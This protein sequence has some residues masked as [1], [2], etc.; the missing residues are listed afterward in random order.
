MLDLSE[1]VGVLLVAVLHFI[2]DA[3]DPAGILQQFAAATAPGSYVAVSHAAPATDAAGQENVRRLYQ[4]TPTSL[5]VRSPARVAE[6]LA[7]WQ[8]L[9]PGLVPISDWHPDPEDADDPPQH[10]VVGGVAGWSA[11]G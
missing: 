7:G 10:A 8:L 11:T 6:L 2:D 5:H 9:E 4:R 1:P 3:D